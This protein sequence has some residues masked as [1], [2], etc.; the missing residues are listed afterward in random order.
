MRINLN[1]FNTG[2]FIEFTRNMVLNKDV[3]FSI[4]E[5]LPD[6]QLFRVDIADDYY[7]QIIEFLVTRVTSEYFSTSQKKQLVVKASNFQLII[8]QLYKLGPD[9]IL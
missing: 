1:N 7:D 4:D 9:E 8:G 3:K 6:G 5:G 2:T